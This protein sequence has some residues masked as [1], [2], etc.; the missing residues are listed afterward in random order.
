MKRLIFPL[1]VFIF[2]V[3][4]ASLLLSNQYWV[5]DEFKLVTYTPGTSIKQLASEDTMT[6]YARRMFFTNHPTLQPKYLFASDCPNGTEQ[7]VVLGCYHGGENGI[8]L[9]SVSDPRLYGIEQVTAAHE[10]LHAIYGQLPQAEK[11]KVDAWLMAFYHHGL[12]DPVVKAQI[13]AYRKS[14]P[15]QVVNEMHSLFATEV[16]NLPSNLENYY[17]K[18]FHDRAQIIKYYSSYE[19]AF[20]SR[21][22]KITSYDDQL[23]YINNQINGLDTQLNADQSQLKNMQQTMSGLQASGQSSSYNALVPRYNSLVNSYNNLVGQDKAL[24]N[25]YNQIVKIRNSLALEEQQLVKDI[26]SSA[27]TIKK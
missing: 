27:P 26:T 20:T 22:N 4:L 2:V 17:K 3:V 7:T 16:A 14:E 15:G 13:A 18:Y 6:S 1:A 25:Q 9:L 24:I 12:N 23:K 8:Y 11:N 19:N 5:Y 10:T 21:Q